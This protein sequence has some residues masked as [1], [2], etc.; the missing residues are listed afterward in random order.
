MAVSRAVTALAEKYADD[1]GDLADDVGEA[2]GA[3]GKPFVYRYARDSALDGAVQDV[4]FD[5]VEHVCMA[6]VRWR[7]PSFAKDAVVKFAEQVKRAELGQ[8]TPASSAQGGGATQAP[9]AASAPAAV[10]SQGSPPPP[11]YVAQAPAPAATSPAPGPAPPPS[12]GASPAPSS[13]PASAAPTAAAAPAAP[14]PPSCTS[15]RKGV[16]HALA[17]GRR[18]E[19]DFTECLRRTSNDAKVCV[20]YKM[21]VDEATKKQAAAGAGLG[22]CLNKGLST[23][24]RQALDASRPGHAARPIETR[25]DGTLVLWTLS[26]V[27]DTAFALEVGPD[28]RAAG[29]T[30]L[31]ANQVQWLRQQL[32][33]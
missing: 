29:K 13:A 31:A 12:P 17:S 25:P 14:S 32:G 18:A 2:V 11:A 24:L 28:G 10:P 3:D 15:E 33:L 7:P 21:Y 1:H 20:R 22:R 16:E 26:P 30:P 23:K 5:P 19:A 8:S 4:Q 6:V 9:A 27:D